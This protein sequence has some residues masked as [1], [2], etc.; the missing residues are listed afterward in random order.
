MDHSQEWRRLHH[1]GSVGAVKGIWDGTFEGRYLVLYGEPAVLRG[2]A[3]LSL[4]SVE[5]ACA[6]ID[7]EA[8]RHGHDCTDRCGHWRQHSAPR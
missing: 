2:A 5:D 6:E 4:V 1:D 8:R 3:S 7:E